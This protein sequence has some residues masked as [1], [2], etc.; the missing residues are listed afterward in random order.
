MK[1]IIWGATEYGYSVQ[2]IDDGEIVDEYTAGNNRCDSQ[3]YVD[4]DSPNA[5][6]LATMRQFAE[7]T[8]NEI[9]ADKGITNV[10][11]DADLTD[12]LRESLSDDANI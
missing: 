12:A 11:E 3:S 7:Q 5:L 4:L 9:A 10:S 8:A 6:P 2:T 1:H